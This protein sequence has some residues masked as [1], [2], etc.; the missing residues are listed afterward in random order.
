MKVRHP[1]A[2]AA[3]LAA[4][5]NCGLGLALF[6]S[7]GLRE[8]PP[9]WHNAGGFPVSLREWV[10]IA[11]YPL[12]FLCLLLAA[13]TSRLALNT[14][15]PSRGLRAVLFGITL[16]QWILITAVVTVAVWNNLDNLIN[17]RPLHWHPE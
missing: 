11:F 6:W 2:L 1:P 14:A 3:I 5:L 12:T 9:F 13:A 15:I 7:A 10:L 4:S 8:T 16:A 17:G